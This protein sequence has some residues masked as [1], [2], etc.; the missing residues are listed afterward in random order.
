MAS[1]RRAR[2]RLLHV[3][4]LAGG[5]GTRFWPLSRGAWPKPLLRWAG[6]RTLLDAA[7]RRAAA[8]APP[9]RIWVV[10]PRALCARIRTALPSLRPDRLIAEPSAR[11]TAPALTLACAV[12]AASEPDATI[13]AL[14]SDQRVSSLRAF[15]TAIAAAERAARDG[16]LVCL[17]ARVMRPA[18]GF[19]YLR[20]SSR[21]RGSRAVRVNRF[22][23]KPSLAAA[24][25]YQ[26]SGRHL[27]NAGIFVWRADA[28][29]REVEALA[30]AVH[31]G[32]TAA[33]RGD[34]GPWSRC[35]RVSVDVAVMERAK[36]VAAVPLEGGWEDLGSWA[37]VSSGAGGRARSGAS[38]IRVGSP[39][40]LVVGGRRV[41]GIVGIPD[42]VVVETDDALLVVAKSAAE[43][44]REIPALLARRGR[45]DLL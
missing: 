24:R 3:V 41:V 1:A 26:R 7:W 28:F 12:I 44:V 13:A 21:P 43:R 9:G 8:I 35:P 19:G 16:V 17:G 32:A 2:S 6:G 40:S 33:A 29:L 14:P 15:R 39:G 30:P 5:S 45:G 37:A 18:T 36:R 34:A 38:V 20:L 22:V 31:R 23:E 27:W 4:I 25:T 10:A 42:A 11:N